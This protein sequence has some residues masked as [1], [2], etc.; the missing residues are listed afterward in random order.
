[1]DGAVWRKVWCLL[2]RSVQRATLPVRLDSARHWKEWSPETFSDNA[3]A[4]NRDYGNLL[5]EMMDEMNSGRGINVILTPGRYNSAF[6]E[7][8]Y[9]AENGVADDK[10]IYYFVPKMIEY[11]LHEKPILHNAPTYLPYYKED[12]DYILSNMK[13]NGVVSL[14]TLTDSPPQGTCIR[15]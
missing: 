7:H 8:S 14:Y 4:D 15:P 3:V 10:G 6:F 12:Y 1:M 11:Y 5:K 2:K 9:L 13:T